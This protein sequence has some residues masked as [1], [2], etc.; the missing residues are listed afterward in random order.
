MKRY[1]KIEVE[2]VDFIMRY[3]YQ[4]RNVMA[5]LTKV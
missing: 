1:K 5:K 4:P 3:L 2:D